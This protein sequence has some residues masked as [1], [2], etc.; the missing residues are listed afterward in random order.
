MSAK[1]ILFVHKFG[2]FFFTPPPKQDFCANV[3]YGATLEGTAAA[4]FRLMA[5]G[6][7]ILRS[8]VSLQIRAAHREHPSI[9]LFVPF[10]TQFCHCRTANFNKIMF[11]LDSV[12]EEAKCREQKKRLASFSK[13]AKRERLKKERKDVPLSHDESRL[14]EDWS[15]V[16]V[17]VVQ[18]VLTLEF[19]GI[20]AS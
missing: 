1:S 19:V 14:W 11:T 12:A 8:T 15:T 5:C 6:W 10:S 4:L 16:I 3:I 13:A 2:A 9:R 7:A 17:V 20:R 18:I